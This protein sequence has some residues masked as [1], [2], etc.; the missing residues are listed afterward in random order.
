MLAG[1]AKASEWAARVEAWR[2]SGE[3]AADF[4]QGREYR[5][6]NLQ[7][8]SSHLK[9][10]RARAGDRV[11]LARVVRAPEATRTPRSSSIVVQLGAARVEVWSGADRAALELVLEALLSAAARGRR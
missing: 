7:W 9:R 3:R 6:K 8:W 10:G 4:C 5:A 1:M 2:A 11:A